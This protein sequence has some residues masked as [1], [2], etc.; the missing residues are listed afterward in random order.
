MQLVNN[1]TPAKDANETGNWPLL[2]EA[3][4]KVAD[5]EP[6]CGLAVGIEIGSAETIHPPNK[7]DAGKR[8]ALVALEK[9]YGKDIEASCPRYQS[10]KIEGSTIRIKLSHAQGMVAK[11]GPP[12]NFAIAGADKKF[13]WADAKQEGDSI[14]VSSHQVPQPIAVRYAWANNPA[15]CNL[16]NRAGLPAAPFRTDDWH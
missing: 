3:Q 14:V 10:M 1:G 6:N 13:F 4:A 8:L 11:D 12:K 15:G 7:Q 5:T 16:Y 2:R 9:D